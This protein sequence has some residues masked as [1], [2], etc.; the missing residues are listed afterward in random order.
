M[1]LL[2]RPWRWVVA[3]VVATLL[4][5]I[6]FQAGRAL[7]APQFLGLP[8]VARVALFLGLTSLLS[9]FAIPSY[10]KMDRGAPLP[11]LPTGYRTPT[12]AQRPAPLTRPAGA[13]PPASRPVSTRSSAQDAGGDR[14]SEPASR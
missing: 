14:R 4:L 12:R 6:V 7:G 11:P 9:A 13:T 8:T 2:T 3:I 5:G 10:E 1:L